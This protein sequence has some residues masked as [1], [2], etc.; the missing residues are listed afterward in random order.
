MP[1]LC[2]FK[3]LPCKTGIGGNMQTKP[4]EV[5]DKFDKF[6]EAMESEGALLTVTDSKGRTNVMTI[7]WALIGVLWYEPIMT[8]YVR[9]SRHTYMLMQKAKVFSVSIPVNKMKEELAFCGSNSGKNVNKIEKCS[10]KMI[11]GLVKGVSIVD[12]CDIYYECEIV[13][14]NKVDKRNLSSGIDKTY[15]QNGDYHKIY[16]GKILKSYERSE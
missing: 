7:G 13:H 8:V 1:I 11:P 15:Y 9:P 10:F 2:L 16:F 4:I 5:F 14:K 12:G 3:Y 6:Y